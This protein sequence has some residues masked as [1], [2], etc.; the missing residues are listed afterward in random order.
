[1]NRPYCGVGLASSVTSESFPSCKKKKK[2]IY[3]YI[4]THTHTHTQSSRML[5]SYPFHHCFSTGGLQCLHLH[6]FLMDLPLFWK[7]CYIFPLPIQHFTW[8]CTTSPRLWNQDCLLFEHKALW[9][10]VTSHTYILRRDVPCQ[11]THTHTH[12]KWATERYYM[13]CL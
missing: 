11:H 2:Y 12:T 3:I 6:V 10:I 4:Y 5:W 1:M 9:S 8:Y 7:G 13:K